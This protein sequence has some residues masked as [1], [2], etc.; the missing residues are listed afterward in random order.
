MEAAMP[1][2]VPVSVRIALVPIFV[3]QAVLCSL[4]VVS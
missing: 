3:L 4:V 1:V 2:H